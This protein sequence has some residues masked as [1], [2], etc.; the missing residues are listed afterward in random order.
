M[1]SNASNAAL[2]QMG[3]SAH[4]QDQVMTPVSLSTMGVNATIGDSTSWATFQ[5]RAAVDCGR[6]TRTRNTGPA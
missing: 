5:Y 1:R 6:F 4:H 3:D 2:I